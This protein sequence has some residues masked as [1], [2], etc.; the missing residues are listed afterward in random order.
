MKRYTLVIADSS[1]D[2]RKAL[3]IEF[4]PIC[5]VFCCGTGREALE[6]LRVRRPDV[7][8]LDLM[9]P[10]LDGLSLLEML[11]ATGSCPG[12][13]VSAA[14][15]SPYILE[16]ARK[17][18]VSYLLRRPFSLG[19]A[20]SLIRKLLQSRTASTA[21]GRF[22]RISGI[23][24]QLGFTAKLRGY[25]Y[26][27][28]AVLLFAENPGQSII[29]DLYP[30]VAGHYGVTAEDVEHSIRSAAADAWTH[31]IRETWNLYFGGESERPSNAALIQCLA[32]TLE[33][34]RDVF[35]AQ[36]L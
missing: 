13:L 23:L 14:Y 28:D 24:L 16:T 35:P 7:L 4:E 27:R 17:L 15:V 29:K 11:S 33:G 12:I 20:E 36:G 25:S 8:V 9:L 5:Q 21:E 31:S 18:G 1:E 32:R 26:L 10:E 19:A 30:G 6:L 2:L 22:G 3:Q 34:T